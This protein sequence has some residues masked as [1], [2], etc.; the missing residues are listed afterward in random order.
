MLEQ[1]ITLGSFIWLETNKQQETIFIRI[2]C[3]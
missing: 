1:N 2:I 3:I